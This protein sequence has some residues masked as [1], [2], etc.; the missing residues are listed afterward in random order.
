[1]GRALIIILTGF[2]MLFTGFHLTIQQTERDSVSSAIQT[3]STAQARQIAESGINYMIAHLKFD[4]AWRGVKAG[5]PL[6][7]GE[8]DITVINR[9]DISATAVEITSHGRFNTTEDSLSVVVDV[10]PVSSR[11]SRYSY[12][13]NREES[14]WFYSRDTL[15]GPVHT[16]GRF[17]MTGTPTFYGLVSSVSSTYATMGYTNPHFYGGTNFGAPA[18]TLEPNFD[19]LNNAAANGGHSVS[20]YPLYLD[21]QSNGTYLYRVGSTGS[22]QSRSIPENGV[23]YCNRNIYV[24]GVVNGAVTLSS[25]RSIYITD[26]LVYADNPESNPDSDDFTG[27]VAQTDVIIQNN[28]ETRNGVIIQAAILAKS[29]SFKAENIDFSPSVPLELWGGIVQEMRGAIGRLGSP[30]T[31]FEKRYY[32]DERMEYK[33]PPHYPIAPGST[34]NLTEKAKIT[35]YY[36][37]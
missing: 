24:K 10:Q 36:W 18:V 1:M 3:Y 31:G 4:P 33:Y 37:K 34:E 32:Y 5:V 16:N 17:N 27:L 35:V 28:S 11:F 14:I 13:S 6:L 7:M 2:I 25:T 19:D 22:W 26:D 29:G 12:F 30:P 21:F 15:S 23:I 20:N 8:T 9:A